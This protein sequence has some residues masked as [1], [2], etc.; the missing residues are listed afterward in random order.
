MVDGQGGIGSARAV[1]EGDGGLR[2]KRAEWVGD[3]FAITE[4]RATSRLR[5]WLKWQ[6]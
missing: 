5:I 2:T 1:F 3:H 4:T 6:L